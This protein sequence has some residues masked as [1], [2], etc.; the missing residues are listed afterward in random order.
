MFLGVHWSPCSC[1]HSR[2]C[3]REGI[4]CILEPAVP[5]QPLAEVCS[6][7]PCVSL[8]SLVHSFTWRTL[9]IVWVLESQSL[10]LV[11]GV[12]R[13]VVPL[14][15][16]QKQRQIL[17]EERNLQFTPKIIQWGKRTRRFYWY[18]WELET[19]SC[20]VVFPELSG[21]SNNNKTQLPK[22][23]PINTYIHTNFNGSF[24]ARVIQP[25]KEIENSNLE[26][27]F[28]EMTQSVIPRGNKMENTEE[29]RHRQNIFKAWA[30]VSPEAWKEWDRWRSDG[31]AFTAL[32][33]P[34]CA[35]KQGQS[36]RPSWQAGAF[37]LESERQIRGLRPPPASPSATAFPLWVSF[38]FSFIY[39]Q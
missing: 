32:L 3:R 29:K 39:F 4:K 1:W 16:S 31:V 20:N 25:K 28:E 5:G 11:E 37:S 24:T 36:P 19:P 21:T 14:Y 27:T 15:T 38:Y 8:I 6:H 30:H 35:E 9:L 10:N 26:D 12:L 2:C 22:H 18:L 34:R 13:L 33:D 23:V 7:L 17:L